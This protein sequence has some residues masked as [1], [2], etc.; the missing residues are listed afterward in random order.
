MKRFLLLVLGVILVFALTACSDAPT[1]EFSYYDEESTVTSSGD[2]AVSQNESSSK[3]EGTRAKK[4][5]AVSDFESSNVTSN[6]NVSSQPESDNSSREEE[7]RE[8]PQITVNF[9]PKEWPNSDSEGTY[10]AYSN[11]IF[12]KGV[13]YAGTMGKNNGEDCYAIVKVGNN[14]EYLGCIAIFDKANN[15]RGIFNIYN[16]RIYYL[17]HP[18][19]QKPDYVQLTSLTICSMDLSGKD[20]R[21]VQIEEM[22]FTNTENVSYYNNSKYLF[23]RVDD[24]NAGIS[25]HDRMYRYNMETGEFVDL[26]YTLGSHR[27]IFSIGDRVFVYH[28]YTAIYEYDADFKNEQL[29]FDVSNYSFSKFTENGFVLTEVTTKDKYLLDFSGNLTKQ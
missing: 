10:I 24:L 7:I 8:E 23:F 29:F 4:D 25:G 15:E 20:K 27:T 14:D 22:P 9:V 17:Q 12:Y 26:N 6:N 5:K 16:D 28:E 1:D 3:V 18:S 13:K 2:G 19:Y 11:E 21:V